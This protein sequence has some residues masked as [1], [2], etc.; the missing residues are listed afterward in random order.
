VKVSEFIPDSVLA[1]FLWMFFKFQHVLSV[2]SSAW[3]WQLRQP[4][5]NIGLLKDRYLLAAKFHSSLENNQGLHTVELFVCLFVDFPFFPPLFVQ[6]TYLHSLQRGQWKKKIIGVQR[7]NRLLPCKCRRMR[8]IMR[9]PAA[10]VLLSSVMAWLI[11]LIIK[12]NNYFSNVPATLTSLCGHYYYNWRSEVCWHKTWKQ[13]L[14][15]ADNLNIHYTTTGFKTR[16][17]RVNIALIQKPKTVNLTRR[18]R[19]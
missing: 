7:T 11:L 8:V 9:L 12:K 2:A 15:C 1:P 16:H 18:Q 10:Y 5:S 13:L 4:R 14:Q 6:S 3:L 17:R 19:L